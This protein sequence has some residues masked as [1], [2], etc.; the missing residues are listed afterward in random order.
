MTTQNLRIPI[1]NVDS[2]ALV[3][4]NNTYILQHQTASTPIPNELSQPSSLSL[5]YLATT[6]SHQV[7]SASDATTIQFFFKLFKTNDDYVV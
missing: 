7:I 5:L 4:M 1:T 3:S 6:F 2:R